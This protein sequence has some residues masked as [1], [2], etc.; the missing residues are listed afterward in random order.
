MKKLCERFAV[1]TVLQNR[2]GNE[3][4]VKDGEKK[5]KAIKVKNPAEDKVPFFFPTNW[6]CTL[7]VFP[8]LENLASAIN[9]RSG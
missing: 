3:V 6:D 8:L 4:R 7:R 5:V 9:V 1:N 2:E